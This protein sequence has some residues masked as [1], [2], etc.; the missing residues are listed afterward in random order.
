M[1]VGGR[2][3]TP[4]RR[5]SKAR[6]V[7]RRVRRVSKRRRTKHGKKVRRSRSRKIMRG[8]SFITAGDTEAGEPGTPAWDDV[9]KRLDALETE[10]TAKKPMMDTQTHSAEKTTGSFVTPKPTEKAAEKLKAIEEQLTELRDK[11]QAAA[12]KPVHPT[13]S[14]TKDAEPEPEPEQGDIWEKL[15]ESRAAHDA[16][17]CERGFEC[18]AQ[19]VANSILYEAQAAA[20]ARRAA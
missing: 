13:Q 9:M 10:K 16:D 15:E 7:P 6:R 8:G 4:R 1:D 14:T 2:R 3:R 19:L 20:A 11:L 17:A 18:D 12:P 5:A